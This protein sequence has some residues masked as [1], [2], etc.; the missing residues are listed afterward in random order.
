MR[1]WLSL[2]ALHILQLCLILSLIRFILLFNA[3]NTLPGRTLLFLTSRVLLTV[4]YWTQL[5]VPLKLFDHFF[6]I[7]SLFWQL[8]RLYIL[9]RRGFRPFVDSLE[10]L[11]VCGLGD[12]V[13]AFDGFLGT[14]NDRG[15][16]FKE[17]RN[18]ADSC[19]SRV[20]SC[21]VSVGVRELLSLVFLL[22]FSYL[23]RHI[24]LLSKL[25]LCDKWCGRIDKQLI[26][27][28]PLLT[29]FWS[30]WFTWWSSI[31]RISSSCLFSLFFNLKNGLWIRT[32][33]GQSGL[34]FLLALWK[35]WFWRF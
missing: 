7:G 30:L 9:F 18:H 25:L 1:L 15:G 28:H 16:A 29:C 26:F 21:V 23:V 13:N 22:N 19:I 5:G 33:C 27:I 3:R 31:R 32:F 12:R 10:E 4:Q 17:G 24:N 6:W 2:L 11:G 14:F 34:V 8:I 35:L 20:A